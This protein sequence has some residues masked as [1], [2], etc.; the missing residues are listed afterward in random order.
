MNKKITALQCKK[1]RANIKLYR[2]S[3][4]DR[5]KKVNIN[6]NLNKLCH[7]IVKYNKKMKNLAL[8]NKIVNQKNNI[9]IVKNKQIQK[10]RL[11]IKKV[12]SKI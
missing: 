12:I 9:F 1:T 6:N 5:W 2:V 3:C 11:K 7:N 10:N 4:K 8:N